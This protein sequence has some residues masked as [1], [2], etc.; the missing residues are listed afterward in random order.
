MREIQLGF[1][2]RQKPDVCA[3]VC[4]TNRQAFPDTPSCSSNENDGVLESDQAVLP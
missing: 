2:P 4:E 1:A 3:G